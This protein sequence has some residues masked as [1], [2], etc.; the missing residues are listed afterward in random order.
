MILEIGEKECLVP[1][2]VA[3][4]HFGAPALG[5]VHHAYGALQRLSP[6][7]HDGVSNLDGK[8]C[9]V[10]TMAK[11]LPWACVGTSTQGM[12]PEKLAEVYP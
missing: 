7:L 8:G 5:A 2:C 11:A 12:R 6:R 3:V 10:R 4:D 1:V 9:M